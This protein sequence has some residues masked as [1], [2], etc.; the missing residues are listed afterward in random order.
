[1]LEGK[2]DISPGAEEGSMVFEICLS[3]NTIQAL[4]E[5]VSGWVNM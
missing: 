3:P 5:D 1:M 4:E 2:I